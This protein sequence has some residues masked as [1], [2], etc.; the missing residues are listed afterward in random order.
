MTVCVAA[1]ANYGKAIVLV[2]DKALTYGEFPAVQGES[3]GIEKILPIGDSGWQ[4]LLS[5]NTTIA[6]G[7]ARHMTDALVADP[8]LAKSYPKMMDCAKSAYQQVREDAVVDQILQPL[9][10]T[11]TDLISRPNTLLPIPDV[12]LHDAA[13]QMRKFSAGCSLLVCGFDEQEGGR[14]FTV[15]D[16]GTVISHDIQDFG[17]I[18][19]GGETARARML[20]DEA[21]REDD[22]DLAMYQAFE[23]KA[24][25]EKVQ[26]VGSRS[27]IWVM[28]PGKIH[29]IPSRILDLLERVFYHHSQMPFRKR[30]RWEPAPAPPKRWE[31]TLRRFTREIVKN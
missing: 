9:L 18:G 22:L 1:L 6:E 29:E 14:I 28:T 16:P 19:I 20:W 5:G 30:P 23:A 3:G 31:S 10:L 17:V 2:S 11:K 24:Y 7:I 15:T 25:A 13:D 21:E 27:D 26:G 8:D 4:A 12:L